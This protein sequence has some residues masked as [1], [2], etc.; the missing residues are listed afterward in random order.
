[1]Y[2]WLDFYQHLLDLISPVVFSVGLLAVRWYAVAYVVAFGVVWALLY[3]RIKKQEVVFSLDTTFDF[4]LYAFGGLLVGARLG[5]VLFYNW[6]FFREHPWAIISPWD[7]SGQLVGIYGMS[8]HGGLVGVLIVCWIFTR[9]HKIA[10][11]RWADF[12]VPAIPAGFFF[13]RL[14][15]FLNGELFGRVT[16]VQWGMYFPGDALGQIR[17]PSQLYEALLEGAVLFA[18]LWLVRKSQRV[19]GHLL[20]T[21]LILFGVVRFGAEFY[22]EPD[23]QI[24]FLFGLLT[25]GQ[26]FSGLMVLGAL[27]WLAFQKL[28][29]NI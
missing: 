20:E 10:F 6:A 28:Q 23:P 3:Y 7:A 11:A 2:T 21:Y 1:M 9:R 4:L 17:H 19:R 29:K 26:L 24:G 12:V 18:I 15:N 22:R 8:Y 16:T 14:G 13:G 25:L 27:V 5:Y